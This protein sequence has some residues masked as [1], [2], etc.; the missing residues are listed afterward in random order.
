MP[1]NYHPQINDKTQQ[2]QDKMACYNSTDET[3]DTT[4]ENKYGYK[5]QDIRQT[6]DFIIRSKKLNLGPDQNTP[7]EA[8]PIEYQ[9]TREEEHINHPE[10]H[11]RINK[12]NPTIIVKEAKETVCQQQP[13]EVHL[14]KHESM[15][16]SCNSFER[17]KV[18]EEDVQ[19][20]AKEIIF[21]Q[22]MQEDRRIEDQLLKVRITTQ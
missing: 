10:S 13:M 8:K 5:M 16:E 9:E 20:K 14:I 18:E 19:Q 7:L 17:T 4:S 11:P 12:Q 22:K 2:E 6:R 3:W 15:E 21:Q 1:E